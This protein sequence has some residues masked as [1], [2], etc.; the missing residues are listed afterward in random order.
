M[1]CKSCQSTQQSTFPTEINIHF[2]GRENLTKTSVWAFPKLLVCLNCGFT[3]FVLEP[4]EL[5]R[6]KEGSPDIA[7]FGESYGTLN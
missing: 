4:P 2:P 6:L 7:G 3:E 1:S 5:S